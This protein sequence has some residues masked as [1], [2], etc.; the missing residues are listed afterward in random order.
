MKLLILN[1]T[2]AFLDTHYRRS[3]VRPL[4]S[5]LVSRV[6]KACRLSTHRIMP[7]HR[8]VDRLVIVIRKGRY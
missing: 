4:M 1:P 2:F 3:F 6:R 5:V 8:Y 7:L